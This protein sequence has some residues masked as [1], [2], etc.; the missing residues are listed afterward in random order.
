MEKTETSSEEKSDESSEEFSDEITDEQ[1]D[2]YSD[3]KSD[4]QS[5]AHSDEKTD[6]KSDEVSDEES[7]EKSEKQSDAQ[8]DGKTDE[9]S[10][11]Q[12]DAQSD[13]QSDVQSD[14]KS[15]NQSDEESDAQS[16]EKT[17]GKTDEKTD[18]QSDEKSDKIDD[19]F[20]FII[21]NNITN[22][23]NILV[24]WEVQNDLDFIIFRV[25]DC[26]NKNIRIY[27]FT[28]I[29]GEAIIQVYY[30]LPKIE[31]YYGNKV[32]TK[33]KSYEFN[34]TIDEIVIAPLVASLPVSIFSLSIFDIL[35]T[36]K[37]PIYVFIE[38]YKAWNWDSL[39]E[40]VFLIDFIDQNNFKNIK[41]SDFYKNHFGKW[42]NQLYKSN[43][44]IKIH[45]YVN[46]Y[47][48][49]AYPIYFIANNIPE[50][51]YDINMLSDGT[52]SFIAFNKYF[53]NN[54][55]YKESYE[56]MK[57]KWIEFKNKV[58]N[59][60]TY[61]NNKNYITEQDLRY[62]NYIMIK[63]E[64]NIYWWLTRIKGLFAPNNPE[65][66]QDL[67]NNSHILL[68][69]TNKLL[70]SLNETEKV[71]IKLLFNFNEN[72]FEEAIKNNKSI[73][74]I[75][76]TYNQNEKN[77]Y[78]YIKA[79]EIYNGLDYFYYYK[80]HPVT[81]TENYPYK[82][83]NLSNINVTSIDSNI[84][85]EIIYFFNSNISVSGY[86]TSS[87]IEMKNETLKI[88]FNKEIDNEKKFDIY[89]NY[90]TK[91]NEKYGKYL[92]NNKD[93]IILNINKD[94]L[95]NNEYNFGIYLKSE[96]RIKFYEN[97]SYLEY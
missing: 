57:N 66:L 83:S 51:N 52:G 63:E 2:I 77:L 9:K 1:T 32:K 82:I 93:G 35:N 47:H 17:D 74:L 91:E 30:G 34:I 12:S 56:K 45:F 43:N 90:I 71:Y 59:T 20:N 21:L 19:Y 86:Y 88:L 3:E 60:K 55:T 53:D 72:Y 25:K 28:D 96:N 24:E 76:G 95:K 67:L 27:N 68:K 13:K 50:E 14:E 73:M 18:V 23:V 62:Y 97:E 11:V 5:D 84:P 8:S 15:D 16:D 48:M 46:D 69:E 42:I 64:K 29:T 92:E 40:N 78:D 79:T 33:T 26:E 94:K 89:S 81:P 36:Y 10:D 41:Y 7:D 87:Y 38:R 6:E 54:E 39:P 49:H 4:I 37:C 58:W 61:K 22:S 70:K 85:L 65:V 75:A 80:G 44:K 31:I